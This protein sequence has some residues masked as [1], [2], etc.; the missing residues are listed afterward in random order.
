MGDVPD[1]VRLHFI[2]SKAEEP[3]RNVTY[4]FGFPNNLEIEV[5]EQILFIA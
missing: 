3:F 1:P 5:W 4:C 2:L